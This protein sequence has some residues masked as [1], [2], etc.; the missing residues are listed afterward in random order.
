MTLD[1]FYG[2]AGEL[3]AFY[4]IPKA[5]F[6]EPRFQTLSTDAKML[7]GI[8]LDRMSLSVKNGWLD[9][10]NRV[11]IIFTIEDVKRALCCADNKA[12]K[13]LRELEKF[14]L[15]E[16]KR[17]G[18]GK[19]SLVY[20]KN[21]SAESSKSIFQNRDFHDSGGFKN[22]SQDPS[23]S[24]CNKNKENDTEMSETDPFYSEEADGMSKRTQLEEYFSQSL[25]V[26]LLLRL[27]PDDE[28]AI[29]QIVDLLVDT[30]A[31]NRKMLRIAG[32]DKPAEVVRSRFMTDS[33]T[34][35][36]QQIDNLIRGAYGSK[37]K[38]FDQTI[39]RSVRAA[40]ISAVGKSIF[41]HD[42][43]GKVAE[44]YKSLTREVMANAEKQLKRVAERGR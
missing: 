14:G 20:V 27:C 40:E 21:F 23:K 32:D 31:T 36:G 18:L 2:Q 4:R 3:F 6:Q 33:R 9:G 16:R 5:L 8:L 26:E 17:R 1:Y 12:T 44:A 25:E 34:N 24:R 30:C 28:D 22:A 35:Y 39:P 41:Q 11:F 10:Q 15:I 42:P 43:K 13:L 38:V 7:Y 29:Y 37:I 19:P